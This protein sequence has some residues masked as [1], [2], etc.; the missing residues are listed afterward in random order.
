MLVLSR[1]GTVA[2]G[3]NGTPA[4]PRAALGEWT[5]T[6]MPSISPLRECSASRLRT[7]QWT[8]VALMQQCLRVVQATCLLDEAAADAAAGIAATKADVAAFFVRRHLVPGYDPA[9]DPSYLARIDAA[10]TEDPHADGADRA[11]RPDAIEAR[12]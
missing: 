9:E 4:T 11:G 6:A 12:A 10:L 7:I 8:P 5:E 2:L 3:A 1:V